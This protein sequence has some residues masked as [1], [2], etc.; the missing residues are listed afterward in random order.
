MVLL[1][2]LGSSWELWRPVL[3]ALAAHYDVIAF[4]LPGFGGS[5]P[6]AKPGIPSFA[7][8]V[9]ASLD[10]LGVGEAQLVGNS[11]GGWLALELGRRGRARSVVALSPAGMERGWESRWSGAMLATMNQMAGPISRVA[12][13]VARYAA[14]RVLLSAGMFARPWRLS[15][16]ESLGHVRSYAGAA[17]SVGLMRRYIRD[18]EPQ[19]LGEVACPALIAWGTRDVLLPARQAQRFVAR[20]PRGE[21]RLLRGLGHSPMADDPELVA[22]VIV[23]FARRA[24]EVQAP[25]GRSARSRASA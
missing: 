25:G 12:P 8:A 22:G 9:E 23:E 20:L 14:G 19:G 21:L 13:S 16:E 24:G 5:P 6:L 3:P 11:M 17:K 2:A 10:E 7:D 15:A 4:D 1:H 18:H